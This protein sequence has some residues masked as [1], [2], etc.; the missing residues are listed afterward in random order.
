[1][2]FVAVLVLV[3]THQWFLRPP[4]VVGGEPDAAVVFVGGRG[5]R[6]AEM[7]ELVGAGTVDH[8]LIAAADFPTSNTFRRIC[9]R[10][11][12]SGAE[13]TCLRATSDTRSEARAL[14]RH[15]ADQ[16]WDHVVVVSSRYHLT[17]AALLFSRCFD[18]RV[19]VV[20]G[21]PES[22]PAVWFGQVLH[23]WVA[24]AEAQVR[25]GC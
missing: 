2:G 22:G 4:D 8:V 19:D 5:E 1:M 17:R 18:G 23:E 9:D 11:D 15:A 25:R 20:G 24:M 21:T 10:G 14:A 6:I 12:V 16:G 7:R 3:L 13:L